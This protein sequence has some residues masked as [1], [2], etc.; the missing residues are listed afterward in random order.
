M[1]KIFELQRFLVKQKLKRVIM[2]KTESLSK[3]DILTT[4]LKFNLKQLLI[5]KVQYLCCLQKLSY[6]LIPF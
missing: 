3:N 6:F 5:Y 2:R 1:L 4:T